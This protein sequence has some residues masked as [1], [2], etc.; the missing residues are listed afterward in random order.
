M[1]LPLQPLSSRCCATGVEFRPGDR[2]VSVLVRDDDDFRRLDCLESVEGDLQI[3][4]E[5]LCRWT[6]TY[7]A[8]ERELNADRELRFTA[9]S[10]FLSLTE[11]GNPVEENADLKQFL[12]LMLERKRVLKNR[13][14]SSGGHLQ[15]FHAAS[16]RMVEVPSGEMDA[17]FFVGVRDKLGIL[18]GEPPSA[19][20]QAAQ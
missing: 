20:G 19:S 10:L 4:G 13:G 9:E 11:E 5:F 12:A 15:F 7:K 18:L 1:E 16:N 2:V 6:R 8:P 14:R 3:S 17:S